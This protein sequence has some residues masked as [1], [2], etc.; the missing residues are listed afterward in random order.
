MEPYSSLYLIDNESLGLDGRF[1]VPFDALIILSPNT[2]LC[3][4]F[5]I[6]N[7]GYGLKYDLKFRIVENEIGILIY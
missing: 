3:S 6:P 4:G 5:R 1:F 7:N 2:L